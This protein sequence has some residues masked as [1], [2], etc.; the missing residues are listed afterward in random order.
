MMHAFIEPR[1]R[2]L[3]ADTLGVDVD[4][5]TPEVSLTDDL[6]ADSL[7]LAELA[8]RLESELGIVVPDRMVH[9]LGTYGEL[10]R[11]TVALTAAAQGKNERPIAVG[12]RLLSPLRAARGALVRAELLTP[13]A[14]ETIVE[15]ALRAGPGARLE[16]TLAYGTNEEEMAHVRARFARLEARGV[17]VSAT[18]QGYADSWAPDTP[19]ELEAA[20]HREVPRP[21]D[22]VGRHRKRAARQSGR[23]LDE[24]RAN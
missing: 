3:V 17:D 11:T 21:G 20:W 9:A 7:D 14:V 13:Y 18:K 10:V 19:P 8:V 15:D 22:G 2:H 16:L 24:P 12:I 1:V 5:L 4:E 23:A 6:A